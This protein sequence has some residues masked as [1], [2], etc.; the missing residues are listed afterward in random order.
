MGICC[1]DVAI[2]TRGP[3]VEAQ[4]PPVAVAKGLAKLAA[5]RGVFIDEASA[6]ALEAAG[7]H[8]LVG[9][10]ELHVPHVGRVLPVCELLGDEGERGLK[11]RFLRPSVGASPGA[12]LRV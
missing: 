3:L 11:E 2:V 1:G 5:A 4:G 12:A 6:R 8:V 10:R 9:P 7:Q